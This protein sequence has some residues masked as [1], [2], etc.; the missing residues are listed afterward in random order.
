ML[1]LLC[2]CAYWLG[3]QH[4]ESTKA[5]EAQIAHLNQ[6]LETARKEMDIIR[7]RATEVG[8]RLIECKHD[9][10]YPLPLDRDQ[11]DTTTGKLCSNTVLK[12]HHHS[13]TYFGGAL[14]TNG[15]GPCI[16]HGWG[17]EYNAKERI[18]YQGMYR[19]GVKHGIGIETFMHDRSQWM[20]EWFEGQKFKGAWLL[21]NGSVH[22]QQWDQKN[23]GGL[24]E[25]VTVYS[26]I[27]PRV[28]TSPFPIPGIVS[29]RSAH[30]PRSLAIFDVPH[31]TNA[32][33]VA[34]PDRVY[35]DDDPQLY[36]N[37]ITPI[38][39]PIVTTMA[40]QSDPA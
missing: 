9:V 22:L 23:Q 40:A 8:Q 17:E 31:M 37:G 15:S 28:L 1:M 25:C 20:G 16:K 5:L 38:I 32:R 4:G 7:L 33:P 13:V 10:R 18:L 24:F 35:N 21:A 30:R 11:T 3:S 12:C 29:F 19:R 26:P 14:K 27:G 2:T 39:P 34:H 6:R 36:S